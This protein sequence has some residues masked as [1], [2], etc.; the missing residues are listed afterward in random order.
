MTVFLVVADPEQDAAMSAAVNKLDNQVVRPGV[1]L[2]RAKHETSTAAAT[3]LGASATTP[4]LVVKAKFISG[5]ASS[6][7]VEKLTTWDQ[8]GA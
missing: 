3:A 5:W 2:I 4:A 6:D 1:W 7:I 8:D